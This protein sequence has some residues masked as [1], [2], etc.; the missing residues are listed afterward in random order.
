MF[1]VAK[2]GAKYSLMNALLCRLANNMAF[3]GVGIR[4]EFSDTLLVVR[5]NATL[6][7]RLQQHYPLASLVAK[8]GELRRLVLQTP[9]YAETYDVTRGS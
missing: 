9:G 5:A 8:Q 7:E 6:A 3:P 4:R 2:S 1:S